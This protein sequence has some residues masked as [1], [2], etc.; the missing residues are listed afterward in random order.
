VAAGERLLLEEAAEEL[1][2]VAEGEVKRMLRVQEVRAN[3]AEPPAE[4]RSIGSI[5][6]N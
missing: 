6:C 3:P 2:S 5:A 4:Q 1:L